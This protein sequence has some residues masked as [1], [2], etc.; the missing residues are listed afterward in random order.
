MVSAKVIDGE[1]FRIDISMIRKK[2]FNKQ[3]FV[4][5]GLGYVAVCVLTRNFLLIFMSVLYL[6]EIVFG[7]SMILY[8]LMR[9][10]Y[11]S[12][13]FSSILIPRVMSMVDKQTN[14]LR[15]EL[16][17][18][19]HG[20]VLDVGCATGL[21]FKYYVSSGKKVS[22]VVALEPN[23]MMH[24]ELQETISKL[25][26]SFPIRIRGDFIEDIKEDNAFDCIVLG[27]VLCE[28]PDQEQAVKECY[29][30]LKPGGRVYFSEHVLSKPGTWSR[31][32]QQT[33]GWWWCVIS[34]GC[35]CDR[36]SLK[37]IKSQN[38][39]VLNWTLEIGLP[40]TRTFEI[41]VAVKPKTNVK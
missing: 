21:Y 39:E 24:E 1:E 32:V 29:R 4:F 18:G 36:E 19:I 38:W 25:S 10:S 9:N 30:L 12:K 11:L 3:Y 40:W 22:E 2:K 13:K 7:L 16:L 31:F 37:V 6:I 35:H 27:N 28:I 41:G 23:T 15:K 33:T 17:K 14:P 34:G 8:F 20:K 5:A 26:P